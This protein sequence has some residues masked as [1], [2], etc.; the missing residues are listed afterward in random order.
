MEKRLNVAQD[1]LLHEKR[2]VS[3]IY[4]EVG[5]KNISHFSTKVEMTMLTP[6]VYSLTVEVGI[7]IA[8]YWL[9]DF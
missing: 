4:L 8:G 5:F 7:R 2:K 3:E 1:K 6:N 9:I